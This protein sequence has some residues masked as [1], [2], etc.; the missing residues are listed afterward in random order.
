MFPPSPVP[1]QERGST[2]AFAVSFGASHEGRSF[3]ETT[4]PVGR[5]MHFGV[6]SHY[7]TGQVVLTEGT[8][9]RS[10]QP[11]VPAPGGRAVHRSEFVP[12]A[13]TRFPPPAW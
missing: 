13:V 9:R 12:A 6:Y 10:S 2:S 8:A 1:L 4:T 3:V 7:V 5:P 11:G